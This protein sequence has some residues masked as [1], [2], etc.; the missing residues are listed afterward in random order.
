[1]N[2]KYSIGYVDTIN[3]LPKESWD[4][5]NQEGNLFLSYNFLKLLE[6]SNSVSK[7]KGWQPVYFYLLDNAAKIAFAPCF[8]KYHSQGEYVFD[9]SWANAYQRLG[10]NYYPKLLLASPFSPVTGSRL[11]TDPK[12][13]NNIKNILLRGIIDFCKRKRLSSFH[14]NFF[15]KNELS[16]IKNNDFLVRYGEQFHFVN[17]NYANFDSYLSSL[18]Y[19]KR[20]SIIKE[21][22]SIS[23]NNIKI[24]TLTGKNIKLEH[25]MLM[26]KFYLS[27]IEKKW[28]YDYLSK[29]FFL[30]LNKYLNKNLLFIFAEHNNETIAGSL[31]FLDSDCIFGRYWGATKNFN[32]LHFEVCFYKAIELA[33]EMGIKKVEAGAQGIH[34][35]KRGYLPEQTFSG[36]YIFDPSLRDAIARYLQEE[37]EMVSKE[38]KTIKEAHSPFKS[39]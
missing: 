9:H 10:L 4:R 12:Y 3:K 15:P 36:H 20:K 19:K 22:R 8:I 37:R 6:D 1:M 21:R 13:H 28:S 7:E 39:K 5:C 30:K 25:C 23:E 33:I 27:T 18:S 16:T 26:H 2:K 38:I 17:N 34:K 11:L 32:N 24:Y 35:L 31:N 14:I 29:N